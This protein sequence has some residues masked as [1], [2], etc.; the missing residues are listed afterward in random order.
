MARIITPQITA[1]D[2]QLLDQFQHNFP[3]VERPYLELAHQLGITEEVVLQRLTHLQKTGLISRVGV[4]LTPRSVGVS[5]LAAMRVPE[6]QIE[7][8]AVLINAF[9]EVN[10]NYQREHEFNLW[11]VVTA[12]DAQRLQTILAQIEQQ[13]GLKVHTMPMEQDFHIDLGFQLHSWTTTPTPC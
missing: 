6:E 7:S 13:S 3:L 12:V 10:H 1:L 11:F 8:I 2:H 4:V 9:S 5:T